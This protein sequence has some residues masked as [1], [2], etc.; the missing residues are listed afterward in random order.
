MR[1]D[2]PCVGDGLAF[3][4]GH[5]GGRLLDPTA[6]GSRELDDDLLMLLRRD[7]AGAWRI[8][9]LSGTVRVLLR[10]EP[11]CEPSGP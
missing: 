8:S 10:A 7:P 1:I 3:V 9:H 11:R 6:K 4:R 2:E 5:N